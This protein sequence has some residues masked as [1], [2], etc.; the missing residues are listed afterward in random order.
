M[1][2]TI[3]EYALERLEALQGADDLRRRHAEYFVAIAEDAQPHVRDG[4]E[5]TEWLDRLESEQDNIR[6]ALDYLES[7]GRHELA[8]RLAAA[9]WWFWS[10]RGNL[11]DGRR[12]LERALAG[13]ERPTSARAY[14]ILGVSDIALDT[15]DKNAARLRGEEAL[16]LFYALGEKWGVAC[17]LLTLGLTFAFDEDWLEAQPRFAESVRIFGELG[18]EHWTLQ[19]TRRLAWTYEELGDLERA[20]ALQEDILRRAR[21]SRDEFLQAK[22]LSAL[23]Q[24]A[25]DEGRV[26]Q[27]VVSN[28]Q[29]AHRFYREKRTHEN[30]YWQAV[31]VCRFARALAL[32]GHATTAA[33]LLGCFEALVEDMR[34]EFAT[35]Q[36]ESWV[37]RMNDKTFA[38]IRTRLDE[39][40]ITAALNKGGRHTA[41]EAVALAGEHLG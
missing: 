36:V 22:A 12:R 41:D 28:L 20:G 11:E 13:N 24:Y 21:A 15:G 9:V 33:E 10:L 8:L 5:S 27:A 32:K 3:R 17:S 18:D 29:E 4:E 40:S 38:E 25:L 14:A 19:A 16:A 1:L 37:R 34:S 6:E 30:R 23:A 35:G 31:L 2:E 7:A 26:D 39:S